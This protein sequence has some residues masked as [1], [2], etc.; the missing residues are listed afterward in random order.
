MTE[1][2]PVL[3]YVESVFDAGGR[4]QD[5]A[6]EQLGRRVQAAIDE[7]GSFRITKEPVLFVASAE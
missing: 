4:V 1:V 6:L 7:R 3:R 2:E 5:G